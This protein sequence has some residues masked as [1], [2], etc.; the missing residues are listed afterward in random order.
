MSE[1]IEIGDWIKYETRH[2]E[3]GIG[4]IF[5]IDGTSV[6]VKYRVA[7]GVV[8]ESI[9]DCNWEPIEPPTLPQAEIMQGISDRLGRLVKLANEAE[10]RRTGKYTPKP[11]YR[12]GK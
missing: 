3:R 4:Q 2:G 11:G 7:I 10:A 5:E 8:N 12:G 9:P 6:L 1:Y